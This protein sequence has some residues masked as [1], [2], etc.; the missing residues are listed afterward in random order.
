MEHPA[1][2]TVG[3]VGA[4]R[5]GSVL[6]A[7][8]ARAG[9]RVTGTYAVS[10]A[11]RARAAELLPG[12]PVKDVAAVVAGAELVLLA[13]PDDALGHLVAGLAATGVWQAG[14]IVVHTSGRHGVGILDPARA[15]HVLPLALHP[16]MTFTGT[17]MDLDRLVD[18]AFGVTA[19]D[20]LRPMAE[21]LVLEMG[22]EPVWIAETDRT[23]YHLA[24]AHGANHL[25]TLTSE[26]MQILAS[27]GVEDPQR[28]LGPLMRAAL[29]NALRLGDAALTGPVARGDV[30]T[31]EDHLREL[32][33]LSPEIRRTYVAMARATAL[34]A[35]DSGRLRPA[36]AEPLLE[37]LADRTQP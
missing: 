9:H 4:G 6:G 31:V 30:G 32:D 33:R 1:R 34:R 17:A 21:A 28:V 35:L 7:A 29:D 20:A 8:L 18:C 12:V 16:A 13:V 24:L 25:V 11:S 36:S 37:T 3:V 2:L 26:A 27:A 19:D 5:V 22:G 10:E 14:Q 15:Q 23:A